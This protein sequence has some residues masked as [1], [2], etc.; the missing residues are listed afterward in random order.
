MLYVLHGVTERGNSCRPAGLVQV[1]CRG[2]ALFRRLSFAN[3][4]GA[5]CISEPWNYSM[6]LQGMQPSYVW[7]MAGL[8]IADLGGCLVFVPRLTVAAVHAAPVNL[9][10]RGCP[11]GCRL[12]VQCGGCLCRWLY[13]EGPRQSP[14]PRNH[15]TGSHQPGIP[16]STHVHALLAKRQLSVVLSGV[17]DSQWH[18]VSPKSPPA[19]RMHDLVC[20]TLHARQF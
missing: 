16:C 9:W 1:C 3:M 18:F 20:R 19:T 13:Q 8:L 10:L 5:C 12:W 15:D 17:W 4:Q 7:C 14:V 11:V 6:S 2:L